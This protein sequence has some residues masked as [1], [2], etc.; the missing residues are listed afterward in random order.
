MSEYLYFFIALIPIA[1]LILA[2][3]VFKAPA[4]WAT[5]LVL[6][7][8]ALLAVL[9]WAFP[10]PLLGTAVLEGAAFALWPIMLVI[11]AALFTYNLAE[12]SGS[13]NTIKRMLTGI[14]E[15]KRIQVLILAWG[16]G[17]FLESV[18]GYGTAV[19]IPA[20]ILAAL[21]FNPL[22]AAALS[23][24]ANTVPTAFG[25]V[26]IPVST[27]ATITELPVAPLSLAVGL[28]L[29]PFILLIPFVLVI[30]T[31]GGFKAM[32]GMFWITLASGLAFAIPQ[33]AAAAFLGAELPA[34]LGS[35]TSMTVTI[36][37]AKAMGRKKG[38]ATGGGLSQTVAGTDPALSPVEVGSVP[39]LSPVQ[40]GSVPAPSPIDLKSVPVSFKEGF[41]AWLPYILVFVFVLMASPLIP[42]IK[43]FLSHFK[44]LVPI[45]M[46]DGAKPL[47]FKWIATPGVLII[48]ATFLGGLI[49]GVKPVVILSVLGKTAGQLVKSTITVISILALAKVMGYSGMIANLAAV[50][51]A[52]TGPLFPLFSPLIGALG[53]FVT[54]SDTSS[55]ILFG[56]LQ[57]TVAEGI[58]QSPTWLA[59]ANT[60]GATAGKMISP[61]SIAVATAAIGQTGQEGNILLRTLP[62]CLAYVLLVGFMVWILGPL[63]A[64]YFP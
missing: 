13:L 30:L 51:V 38:A 33:L 31:G 22:F 49:Q 7:L 59:A 21:G 55:N 47:E 50:F 34:I 14:T 52:I 28:Q 57:T 37:I 41:L 23:L 17:G 61:Q 18:A 36:F 3:G 16:F 6:G 42:P 1:G 64:V 5:P 15:D 8:T 12:K 11:L 20:S 4:H 48:L 46:G 58:H 25:A 60:A 54:G 2:L 53:T 10:L 32:K 44:S 9:V 45:Y 43:D 26:G 56:K 35:L 29:T 40:P 24:I 63:A 62:Y 27:L 39:G 19:A